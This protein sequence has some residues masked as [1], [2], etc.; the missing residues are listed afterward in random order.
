MLCNT[1]GRG[2]R[3]RRPAFRNPG[4]PPHE[5]HAQA[6]H[7]ETPQGS[8]QSVS[9]Q[10]VRLQRPARG[11]AKG[12]HAPGLPCRNPSAREPSPLAQ[13]DK[14]VGRL[15]H[16]TDRGGGPVSSAGAAE[17]MCKCPAGASPRPTWP[18]DIRAPVYCKTV[19]WGPWRESPGTE[20]GAEGQF[21]NFPRVCAKMM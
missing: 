6:C 19:P 4:T 2:S 17:Q 8:W 16:N 10:A 5:P 1:V 20:I 11:A 12:A 13:D 7:C 14:S 3:P 18:L 9:P 15:F 21:L